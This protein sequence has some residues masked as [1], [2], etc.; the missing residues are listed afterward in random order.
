MLF[1]PYL[2]QE[3]YFLS[4]VSLLFW[5]TAKM[6]F[7]KLQE[8]VGF[9]LTYVSVL[10]MIGIPTAASCV[11]T[12]ITFSLGFI[13]VLANMIA[14]NYRIYRIFNNIFITSNVITD[15]QLIRTVVALV[16]LEMVKNYSLQSLY[17]CT[18]CCF[19]SYFELT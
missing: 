5:P 15:V 12:P 17:F 16:G 19:S 6:K 1:W 8:L 9:V 14:K 4:F 3:S 7:S 2:L 13:L 18:A 10:M 11:V